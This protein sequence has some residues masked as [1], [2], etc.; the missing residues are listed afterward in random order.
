MYNKNMNSAL[1]KQIQSIPAKP[2]CYLFK[3][4]QGKIIYVG[5]AINL[6]NRVKSYWRKS[7]RL[8]AAKKIMLG[9]IHSI[10]HIITQNEA[11]ALILESSLI[12]KWRPTF[13]IVMRDD[14][15][16]VYLKI[17]LKDDFP[18][19]QI[20]RRVLK[21]KA[22]YF[23]PYTSAKAVKHTL[24]LLRKI[25]PYKNCSNPLAKPCLG[26]H[27]KR[28]L[29]HTAEGMT[30][31]E[32][33][34]IIL[35]IID[36][37]KGKNTNKI[38]RELKQEMQQASQKKNYEK[39]GRLRDQIQNI[40]RVFEQQDVYSIKGESQDILGLARN[41]N[42]AVISLLK[43]RGGKLLTKDDFVLERT[44]DIGDQE[45]LNTFLSQYLAHAQDLPKE[46]ILPTKVTAPRLLEKISQAKIT[47]PERGKKVRLVKIAQTNAAHKLSSIAIEEESKERFAQKAL[48]KLAKILKIKGQLNRL[49]AYDI[50]NIQGRYA[51]GSMV[52]F[53]DGQPNKSQYRKFKIKTVDQA[54][55]TAMIK[56]IL[57]RRFA[58][59][60]KDGWPQPD[61][62]IID[63]GKP[64]LSAGLA[65]LKRLKTKIPIIAI[66]KREEE[67]FAP[68]KK[69]SLKLPKNSPA[70][71]L[72]Q[73]IRDEAH[74]FAVQYYRA[75]H[76]KDS[77]SSA[78]DEIPGIG[79]KKK[80]DLIKNFGSIKMIRQAAQKDVA[81]ITGARAAKAIKEYL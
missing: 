32:Y 57:T 30:K 62:I 1:K 9:K 69:S 2:G 25:F 7:A 22:K 58:H 8:E 27:I 5:K 67:I 6:K 74:R 65:I 59:Q 16:Y 10:E 20:V 52:V 81:K 14:K 56:E 28:C 43:T 68:N 12:K 17:N 61:L 36:F 47:I 26:F 45:V 60:K 21:D 4:K 78:L 11:E 73:R 29:G 75:S 49:E 80:R 44:R 71:Q 72:I 19:V 48:P 46:I 51:T 3:N 18:T 13:N 37:L 24:A 54:N 66:A 23:G 41:S 64:Q 39:A 76:K 77:L 40:E 38:L 70:M 53:A 79:P 63:G 31:Q 42:K 34:K 55:D 50:S 33:R 15:F 35:N